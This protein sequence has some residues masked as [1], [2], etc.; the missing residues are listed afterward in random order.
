LINYQDQYS[1]TKTTTKTFYARPRPCVQD[2]DQDFNL[3]ARPWS[4]G[5]Q[6]WI[7]YDLMIRRDCGISATSLNVCFTCAIFLLL[8]NIQSRWNTSLYLYYCFS[9]ILDSCSSDVDSLTSIKNQ[10]WKYEL[11]PV[12]QTSLKQDFNKIIDGWNTA[13]KLCISLV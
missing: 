9:G 13:A 5:L 11:Y 3:C 2:Q 4:R 12:V 1:K 10:M 7:Y 8:Y 6:H